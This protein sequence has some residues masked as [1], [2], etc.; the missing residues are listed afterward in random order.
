MVPGAGSDIVSFT[1]MPGVKSTDTGCLLTHLESLLD[2]PHAF[3][4]SIVL[5]TGR[6]W[7]RHESAWEKWGPVFSE[8]KL[9]PATQGPQ[10]R[11]SIS[12]SGGLLGVEWAWN[13]WLKGSGDTHCGVSYKRVEDVCEDWQNGNNDS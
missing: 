2:G 13:S 4:K 11:Y 3:S 5:G 10:I 6:N 12:A 9:W 8:E 1:L 7:R